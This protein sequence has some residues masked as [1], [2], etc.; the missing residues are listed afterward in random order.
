MSSNLSRS[1]SF[2]MVSALAVV[3]LVLGNQLDPAAAT[4]QWSNDSV[5]TDPCRNA[6]GEPQLLSA[7]DG[8]FVAIVGVTTGSPNLILARRS[9][10]GG[11][12]WGVATVLSDPTV[13]ANDADAV[14]LNDGSLVVVWSQPGSITG[15]REIRLRQ[16]LDNGISWGAP[17]IVSAPSFPEEQAD[18]PEISAMGSHGIALAY[19]RSHASV[20]GT[21]PVVRTAAD[22]SHWGD[23]VE[24]TGATGQTSDV[25]PTVNE[26]GA[27]LVT[28]TSFDGTRYTKEAALASGPTVVLTLSSFPTIPNYPVSVTTTASGDFVAVWSDATSALSPNFNIASMTI[29]SHHVNLNSGSCV[30]FSPVSPSSSPSASPSSSPTSSPTAGCGTNAA[31]AFAPVIVRLNDGSLLAA[32]SQDT[33][34]NGTSDIRTSR[35]DA[36]GHNWST[37]VTVNTPI[38]THANFNPRL[39]VSPDGTVMVSWTVGFSATQAYEC[40]V[41]NSGGEVWD[42]SFTVSS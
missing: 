40:A 23:L 42:S 10:D 35:G 13:S 31:F 20:S 19:K 28:W 22:M 5:L 6:Q 11:N 27:I 29:D 39:A 21:W 24:F 32:W 1:F 25:T 4:A 36:E 33:N 7:E 34:T 26:S 17:L 30:N 37:P 14:R 16:S 2:I 41:I 38:D 15:S 9:I 12:T 3:A 8:S 18:E